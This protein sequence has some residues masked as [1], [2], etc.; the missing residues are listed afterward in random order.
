L[1]SKSRAVLLYANAIDND[2]HKAVINTTEFTT[3]SVEGTGAVNNK[4]NLVKTPGAAVHFYTKGGNSSAV[5]HIS[6]GKKNANLGA[7]RKSEAVIDFK[8]TECPFG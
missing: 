2:R 3:L 4:A 6:R 1:S 5:Q 8:K 7:N